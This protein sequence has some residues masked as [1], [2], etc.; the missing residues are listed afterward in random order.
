MSF[1]QRRVAAATDTSLAVVIN[2]AANLKSQ[3]AELNELR[4]RVSREL[5]SAQK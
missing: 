3:L 1:S 2:A 5:L 4:E